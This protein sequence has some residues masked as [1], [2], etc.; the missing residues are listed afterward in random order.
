MTYVEKLGGYEAN[1]YGTFGQTLHEVLQHQISQGREH[2]AGEFREWFEHIYRLNKEKDDTLT[3]SD[4]QIT[5]WSDIGER[6]VAAFNKRAE[7]LS[8]QLIAVEYPIYTPLNRTTAINFKGYIDLL[9]LTPESDRLTIYDIKTS[10]RGWGPTD[11]AKGYEQ[12]ALYAY[13]LRAQTKTK[14]PIRVGFIIFNRNKPD[15]VDATLTEHFELS[16]KGAMLM[17]NDFVKSVY[18]REGNPTDRNIYANPSSQACR[19]CPYRINGQC[20]QSYFKYIR[21]N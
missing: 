12:L 21:T 1:I 8:G 17:I 15:V 6:H 13:Y 2:Q 11:K 14:K 4:N 7:L 19:F 5:E 16:Y 9:Y 3:I 10:S 20:D 18:D